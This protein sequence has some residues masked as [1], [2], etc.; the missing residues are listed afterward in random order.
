MSNSWKKGAI[1][2]LIA[3][4]VA[5]IVKIVSSNIAIGI[6]ISKPEYV[7]GSLSLEMHLLR[8]L[9]YDSV[10]GV[11]FGVLFAV[12]YDLIPKKGYVKGFLFGLILWLISV[13]R[14]MSFMAAY[15]W[16]YVAGFIIISFFV[17]SIYGIIL[18]ILFKKELPLESITYNFGN[19]VKAG[20]IAGLI[21]GVSVVITGTL[22]QWVLNLWVIVPGIFSGIVAISQARD[23]IGLNVI[24]GCLQGIIFARIY[25]L[26]PG[27]GITK[28]LMYGGLL[29]LI[30]VI[31]SQSYSLAPDYLPINVVY[32]FLGLVQ[33]IVFGLV[34][35]YLY[36][37]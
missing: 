36:K 23:Y 26:I 21:G 11:I 22:G 28:G 14:P 17:L 27:K 6:E 18:G 15:G 16:S 35:G 12:F 7:F 3:G 9:I 34:L 13:V 32:G 4:I 1:S 30:A 5:G 25:D 33:A 2:G 31:Y 20:I 10:W 19:G 29:F 37:K 24:W 8:I